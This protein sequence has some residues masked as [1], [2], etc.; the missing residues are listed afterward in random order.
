[1]YK[2]PSPLP[3]LVNER[4]CIA[5]TK[6]WGI[7]SPG[8]VACPSPAAS[9]WIHFHP[10][11]CYPLSIY[12]P[13]LYLCLHGG[14]SVQ[15]YAE[16]VHFMRTS[17]CP[18]GWRVFL[19]P[20]ILHSADCEGLDAG[21]SAVRLSCIALPTL[22]CHVTVFA[23]HL[24]LPL[25]VSISVTLTQPQAA[26]PAAIHGN[27]FIL[28]LLVDSRRVETCKPSTSVMHTACPLGKILQRLLS[29]LKAHKNVEICV[30]NC[31]KCGK[32]CE[33]VHKK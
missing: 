20:N 29:M 24:S 19:C 17:A 22:S 16:Q 28:L 15:R 32:L 8:L 18:L 23:F 25:P 6:L 10:G 27:N 12:I 14:V 1:M 33:S 31:G 2:V 4:E 26:K 30:H 3:W 21:N 13:A 5:R 9:R 11:P 7:R